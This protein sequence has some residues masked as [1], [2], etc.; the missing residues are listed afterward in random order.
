MELGVGQPAGAVLETRDG[1][2]LG[3]DLVAA[4]GADG[5]QAGVGLQVLEGL[6]VGGL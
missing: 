5:G 3:V 6:D 2:A 1:E 4:G